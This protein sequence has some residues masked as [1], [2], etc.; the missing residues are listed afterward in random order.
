VLSPVADCSMTC[1]D[2]GTEYCGAGGYL[3]LYQRN[4]TY[5]APSSSSTTVPGSSPTATGSA[6]KQIIGNWVFQGCWTEATNSRAL[7]GTTYA[8]DGI[9]LESCAAFC[10]GSLMF[11]VEYG[12]ECML[13]S[14]FGPTHVDR[15]RLLWKYITGRKYQSNND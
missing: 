14:F 15:N 9:T 3:N 10:K 4:G 6:I 1:S 8:S 2:N 13:T 11:G 12:R 5:I 7:V